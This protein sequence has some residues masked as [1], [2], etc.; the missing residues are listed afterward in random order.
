MSWIR[1]VGRSEGLA[2]LALAHKANE[3]HMAAMM[4]AITRLSNTASVHNIQFDD[5][6][7]RIAA[8]HV[9]D[10][11]MLPGYLDGAERLLGHAAGFVM[12]SLTEGMP[13]VLLEAMQ[14]RVPI[15]ATRVGAIPELLGDGSRGLLVAPGDVAALAAG[16]QKLIGTAD[17]GVTERAELAYTAVSDHYSSARMASEYLAAY[18]EI[19]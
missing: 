18:Q 12:S 10:R 1:P 13:L 8:L 7:A 16:L 17:A 2:E 4:Q 6:E 19:A 5:H 15:L 14:W 9:Q 11:V 3:L